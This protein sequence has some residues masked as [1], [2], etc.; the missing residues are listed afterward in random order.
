DI[1]YHAR[2]R[3]AGI[4]AIGQLPGLEEI[5]DVLLAPVADAL[6]RYVGY[7]ALAF[8]IGATREALSRDDAAEKIARAVTLRAMAKTVDEIGA[9]IPL[10]AAA[11]VRHERTVIDEQ[12]LPNPDIAA[13]VER[14]S[15]VVIAH[16]ARNSR[17]RLQI[18][19]KI[20]DVF[21]LRV[22]VGRIGKGW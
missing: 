5:G 15:H 14:K 7:P 13:D 4:V 21:G 20:A 8:R 9:A 16:L 19:E 18:R 17:Q 10:R 2:H 6:L 11:A 1:S 12:Q 3:A 22:R